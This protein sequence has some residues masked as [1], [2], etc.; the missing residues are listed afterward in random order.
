MIRELAN[1]RA[2]ELQGQPAAVPVGDAARRSTSGSPPTGRRRSQLT[3]EVGDG[4]ILQ[5]ADPDIAAWTI[6][7]VREA[8]ETPAATR[9]RSRSASPPRRTSGDDRDRTCATSAAGSAGWS[10]TTSPTSSPAT[11]P[12]ARVPEALTDYIAGRAGLRLQRARPGRATRTPTSCRTR[13]STGSA[14]SARSR[15]TSSGSRSCA[16]SAS[17]SSPSTSSTTPRTRRCAAYGEH[18]IPAVAERGRGQGMTD[19]ATMLAPRS[20]RRAVRRVDARSGGSRS[21]RP[22]AVACWSALIWELAT[23]SSGRPTAASGSG[24]ASCCRATDDAAMPHV[25]DDRCAGSVEPETH[26][27]PARR[28]CW[29]DA[30]RRLL[31]HA[32]AWRSSGSLVGVVVGLLLAVAHA[33]VALARARRC[34]RG[35]SCSARPSR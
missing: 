24:L 11:A 14:S 20:R 17:T 5:L 19:L 8:A 7:A 15:S 29:R 34:C 33:A 9:T 28:R 23:R 21:R 6:A 25:L 3:G 27:R 4:F 2:V 31:V 30:R 1:G 10:A 16:R 22:L 26:R 13:S 32:A 12:T 35:S 18:V